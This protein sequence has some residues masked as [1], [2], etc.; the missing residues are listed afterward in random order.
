MVSEHQIDY[1]IKGLDEMRARGLLAM[2]PKPSAFAR[3]NA[4]MANAVRETIWFTGGCDSWYLD[5]NGVP[6]IYP[7]TPARY[8]RE[9]KRPDF[10]EFRLMAS[11][12]DLRGGELEATIVQSKL[13]P[14][15]AA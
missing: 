1:L 6:N 12:E 15:L 2:A 9:M 14:A 10:R 5:R 4:A 13:G 7:W 11:E 3:Y 8:R